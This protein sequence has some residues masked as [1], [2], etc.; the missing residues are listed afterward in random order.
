MDGSSS[1]SDFERYF[2]TVLGANIG[3]LYEPDGEA[4]LMDHSR[5][6]P[7]LKNRVAEHVEKA[8]VDIAIENPALG[9]KR[10]SWELAQRGVMVFSSGVRSVWL[11]HD[12]ET[13]KQRLKA[14][15][16]ASAQEGI[17]A[18]RGTAHCA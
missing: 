15:E 14:L 8:M 9:Q 6:K 11:R 5:K 16:A 12:L 2:R 1:A 13:M 4:A 7:V 3:E 17:F 18:E 10:A